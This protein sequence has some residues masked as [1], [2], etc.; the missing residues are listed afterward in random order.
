M[1]SAL[2]TSSK[3]GGVLAVPAP[4]QAPE[5]ADLVT[6]VEDGVPGLPGHP[7]AGWVRGDAQQ[8]DAAGGMFDHGEAVQPGQSDR[9]DM[10]EIGG[11]DP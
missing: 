11:Q 5:V 8:V 10:E 7:L 4:D 1:P 6:Q 9:L 2:N 3:Q